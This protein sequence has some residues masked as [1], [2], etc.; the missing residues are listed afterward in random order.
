LHRKIKG[1]LAFLDYPEGT[2]GTSE[3]SQE[4]KGEKV[5]KGQSGRDYQKLAKQIQQ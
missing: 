5:A 4:A 2:A 1:R 3:K